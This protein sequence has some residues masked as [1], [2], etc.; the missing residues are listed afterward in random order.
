MKI[1]VMDTMSAIARQEWDACANPDPARY[2]PFLAHDFLAALEDSGCVSRRTGWMPQ[3]LVLEDDADVMIGAMPL[4]LKS[5]SRGEYVFDHGWADAYERAGG[6]YYPKLQSCVPFTPVTGRRLLVRRGAD[7]DIAEAALLGGAI[8]LMRLHGASSVHLTFVTEN[9]W[10]AHGRMPVLQRTDQQFH[11]L[12]DGYGSYE[13]FLD[14]LSSRKRKALRK[15]RREAV[16]AGIEIE[17]LTGAAITEAHWDTFFAF[18]QDTGSRKWGSPYLNRRFFGMIGERM[19]DRILLIMCKRAGRYVAGAL[20]LIGGDTLYGRYWGAIEHHPFLH[21]ETCYHQ[22]IDFAIAHGLARVEAGAQGEHK[23]AR[24]YLP[25]TTYSLHHLDHPG[26]RRAVAAFLE[27]ER[28]AVAEEGRV[29]AEMGPF[30]KPACTDRS[31]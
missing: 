4:Y 18:Y 2:N 11:W 28:L 1:R 25:Q 23:L 19:A 17:H 15:E 20:N 24:G 29:L 9:E 13:D 3:H 26:L 30:K 31:P 5:H 10:A 27:Q 8:E 14:T 6:S 21:F 12:N 16:A 7:S 22:A